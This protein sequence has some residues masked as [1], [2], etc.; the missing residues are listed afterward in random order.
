MLDHLDRPDFGEAARTSRAI[1]VRDRARADDGARRQPARPRGV[2]DQLRK[3]ERHLAPRRRADPLAITPSMQGHIEPA[4]APGIADLVRRDRNRREARRRL[5]LQETEANTYLARTDRAQAPVVDQDQQ[6]DPPRSVLGGD[7][8]RHVVH[9]HALQAL[10]KE[11]D[12]PGKGILD[13][14]LRPF[15]KPT[16]MR[17]DCQFG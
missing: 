2:G 8:H 13:A 10:T 14:Y 17:T 12:D 16:A 6:P 5:R 3:R 4:V 15:I 1:G 11:L 9:D 7:G